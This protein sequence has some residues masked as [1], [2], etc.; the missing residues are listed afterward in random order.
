[1]KITII[2]SNLTFNEAFEFLQRGL[3]IRLPNWPEDKYV[4]KD[5][6]GSY[7]NEGGRFWHPTIN[8]AASVWQII[9]HEG[10]QQIDVLKSPL[11]LLNS[12]EL[13]ER[14]HRRIF[15]GSP[16]DTDYRC[17]RSSFLLK[18]INQVLDAQ[19]QPED[20]PE[21]TRIMALRW[22]NSSEADRAIDMGKLALDD[23]VE[24]AKV[25][26]E[27][28]KLQAEFEAKEAS[29]PLTAG[30]LALDLAQEWLNLS[31]V[32]RSK[33]E[34]HL[35]QY[36]PQLC[37]MVKKKLE[38]LQA[39]QREVKGLSRVGAAFK[40]ERIRAREEELRR[41][42]RAEAEMWIRLTPEAC[43]KAM[44]MVNLCI[45]NKERFIEVMREYEQLRDGDQI[46]AAEPPAKN[47]NCDADKRLAESVATRWLKMPLD[48]R[49]E[50]M[51]ELAKQHPL[52][53]ASARK[54]M[55]ELQAGAQP[56]E[57]P[58]D[59]QLFTRSLIDDREGVRREYPLSIFTPGCVRF[60]LTRMQYEVPDPLTDFRNRI[61]LDFIDRA[62]A[63]AQV[64]PFPGADMIQQ[65]NGTPW[66][67]L[68][69]WRKSQDRRAERFA[70]HWLI[71]P[72]GPSLDSALKEAQA[73]HPDIYEL[74]MAKFN[75]R[76]RGSETPPPTPA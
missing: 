74:A 39:G 21:Y 6:G 71:I 23:Q 13:V 24:F 10:Y 16:V 4:L 64:L 48:E 37:A 7:V 28:K 53:W 50:A 9:A 1:M 44:A 45:E 73:N 5:A 26:A 17:A 38:E 30:V 55:E 49:E 61:W 75:E 57:A 52:L 54:K 43:L 25:M 56:E 29:E 3:R 19:Q 34:L 12:R 51:N 8:E 65:I 72:A 22:L 76:L 41:S 63:L 70:D 40:A 62:V 46:K 11:E 58:A 33:A 32:A 66:D 47:I 14:V 42:A 35:S 18:E 27:F 59:I 20:V 2:Q 67:V 36:N 60:D 69:S 15:A 68:Q 31:L